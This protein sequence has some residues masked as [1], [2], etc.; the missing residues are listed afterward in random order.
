M[1]EKKIENTDGKK[2]RLKIKL[3][4]DGWRGERGSIGAGERM[5]GN[6]NVVDIVAIQN[7]HPHN[8]EMAT[9]LTGNRSETQPVLWPRKEAAFFTF[10]TSMHGRTATPSLLRSLK[11]T[12]DYR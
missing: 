3:V 8:S 6:Q 10:V 2:L 12:C 5:S 4:K 7:C 1:T 9:G 11:K